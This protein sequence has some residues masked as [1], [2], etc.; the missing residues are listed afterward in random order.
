MK[1]IS[2]TYFLY[3]KNNLWGKTMQGI[4]ENIMVVKWMGRDVWRFFLG[5]RVISSLNFQ[6]R[7][8]QPICEGYSETMQHGDVQIWDFLMIYS[9]NLEKFN[10]KSKILLHTTLEWPQL[11]IFQIEGIFTTEFIKSSHPFDPFFNS[12]KP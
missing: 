9:S 12:N 10:K 5:S 7:S 11:P 1:F 2:D 8:V 6:V 4:A 3:S